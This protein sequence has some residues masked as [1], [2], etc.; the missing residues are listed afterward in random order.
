MFKTNELYLANLNATEDLIINQG[1]TSSSKTYSILQALFSIAIRERCDILVVGQSIP[2][3]KVGALKDAI[4]IVANSEQLQQ[5]VVSFNKTDRIYDFVS[6]STMHF[7]SFQDFQDAKSGKRDYSFFNEVNGIPKPIFDEIYLRTR[8]RTWVDYNPNEEFWIHDYIGK[9]GVK[10]LRTWHEHNPFLS[11]KIRDKIEGLKEIDED[12]WKV[13]A[14]G[15]TGKIEGLVFRKWK[16]ATDV[17]EGAEYIGSG[18]DFGFTNDPSASVDVYKSDGNLYVKE[19]LYRTGLTNQDLAKELDR[20][21]RYVCDSA[22]PKSIEELRRAG[23]K[24]EPANKGKDSINSSIDILKQYQIYLIGENLVKEFKSY[25]W[26]VDKKTNNPTN[27]PVDFMNHLI[28]ALRYVA[29]N[30]IANKRGHRGFA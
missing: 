15:M 26:K 16:Q 7:K 22:E 18:L 30:R 13:Y 10:F 17:P 14:R 27:E 6:G 1:G 4:D 3:L 29:L 21:N 23:L 28:D 5:L 12:L 11:Q 19:S 2:N 9:E 8:K 20:T 25:K 24:V